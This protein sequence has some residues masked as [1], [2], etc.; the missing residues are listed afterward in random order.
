MDLLVVRYG[1]PWWLVECKS[2]QTDPAPAL[3]YFRVKLGNPRCFQ[4]VAK[5]GHDRWFP[6]HGLRVIHHE[7]FLA[8]LV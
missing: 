2:G 4:L 1:K 3:L 7:K 6:A 8:G 5:T